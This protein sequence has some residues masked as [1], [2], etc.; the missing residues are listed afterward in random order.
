MAPP[1]ATAPELEGEATVLYRVIGSAAFKWALGVITAGVLALL[2]LGWTA[3]LEGAASKNPDV[4]AAKASVDTLTVAV[5]KLKETSDGH[6]NQLVDAEKER[7]AITALQGKIFEAIKGV[8]SDVHAL[9][10]HVATVDQKL[11]DLK[12]Q[13][14]AK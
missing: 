10:I 9:D 13:V 12:D 8:G 7:V 1:D 4:V 5:A 3:Y 14:R 11:E 2:A 6:T